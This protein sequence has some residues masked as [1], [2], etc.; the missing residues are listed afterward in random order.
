VHD[1]IACLSAHELRACYVRGDLS[2]V[3]V[4]QALGERTEAVDT[5]LNT[6]TSTAFDQARAE[7]RGSERRYAEGRALP[8]D[9]VPVVV[10]D[11][12]DT[13]GLTTTYGS[14]MFAGHRP[15]RDAR[16]VGRV[17]AAGGIVTGKSATHEFAWGITTEN[18]HYGP[19]HNPWD[20][21]RVP[22]GSSGGSA[23]ALA[24]G[25][26]PLALG[27]DTSGSVRIPAAF[28]GVVG[29]KPT[30]GSVDT[31]G[32]FPLAPSLDHLGPM[33]RTVPDARLLLSVLAE[34]GART[35]QPPPTERPVRD[36]RV[37]VCPDLDQVSLS[38]SA[39]TALDAAAAAFTGLGAD[40]VEVRARDVPPL[41][42]TLAVTVLA[43]AAH[44][45]RSQG[46]WPERAAEY[47]N[48]TRSRLEMSAEVSLTDYLDSRRRR[49]RLHALMRRIFTEVDVLLMPVSAV[50]PVLIGESTVRHEGH[51]V[52]FRELVMTSTA[53]QSLTGYPSCALRAGFNEYGT[54]MGVQLTTPP[55]TE[56][57][58][59]DVAET[60]YDATLSL[61]A[62]RPDLGH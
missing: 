36:L 47:G 55:G 9:G 39:R 31:C 24:A 5:A 25:L 57:L 26:A 20:P 58:L 59:L 61:Q 10:K 48:E 56:S 22:G 49:L 17:R 35:G 45:H 29:L 16:A 53:P 51:R 7:A 44:V 34:P 2:P 28:C 40:L 41:Y 50:P 12:I 38:P 46:L 4:V 42:E 30:F 14:R 11:L 21:G 33:A 13:A 62:R 3:E 52:P 23:A 19:T 6:M 1:E 27:T 60:L 37:G 18:E 43:E 8:L 54:P 15:E 32:V